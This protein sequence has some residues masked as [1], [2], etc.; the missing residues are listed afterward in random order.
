MA[1]TWTITNMEYTNDS[2]KGVVHAAWSA[3]ET[4]GDHTGTVS[5]MESYT[6]DASAEGY[7]AW[8]SLDE[9]T[10]VG[11]VKETLGADECTRVEGKVAD[12]ITKSKTP[13]TSWGVAWS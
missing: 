10:V 13:P 6:P 11:W 3:S 4:D 2:D 12:Q 8:D 7:V 9:S 1:V 5:G